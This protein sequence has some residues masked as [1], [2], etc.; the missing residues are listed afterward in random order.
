MYTLSNICPLFGNNLIIDNLN[1][2]MIIIY[3]IVKLYWYLFQANTFMTWVQL[4]QLI[5]KKIKCKY[6]I[7]KHEIIIVKYQN[8]ELI[9]K[10]NEK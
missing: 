1:G 9:Q 7:E 10:G 2:H 4:I 8:T 6:E 5:Q 3:T